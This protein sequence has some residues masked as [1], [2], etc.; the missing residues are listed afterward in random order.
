MQGSIRDQSH[1]NL[2]CTVRVDEFALMLSRV[3]SAYCRKNTLK[4]LFGW[5]E[6]MTLAITEMK[7]RSDPVFNS[8]LFE[9]MHAQGVIN[10]E[11]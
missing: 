10:I 7:R 9:V 5:L 11:N 6:V 4:L 2:R 1:H 3:S 8:G